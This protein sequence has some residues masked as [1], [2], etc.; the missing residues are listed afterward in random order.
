MKRKIIAA[1]AG[2]AMLAGLPGYAL[3]GWMDNV[4]SR[5]LPQ[6][7]QAS[8]TAPRHLDAPDVGLTTGSINPLPRRPAGRQ[9]AR[10]VQDF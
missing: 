8:R 3:A 2:I 9:P 10:P 5:F 6:T 1:L 7:H 4:P